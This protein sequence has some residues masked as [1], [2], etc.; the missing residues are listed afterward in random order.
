MTIM[1]DLIL[2]VLNLP[3]SAISDVDRM[4]DVNDIL[5]FFLR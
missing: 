5:G 4:R 2:F 1:Y 3:V